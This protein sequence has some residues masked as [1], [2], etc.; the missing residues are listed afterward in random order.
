ML[1]DP[2]AA[3]PV[4]IG[5]RGAKSGIVPY[6]HALDTKGHGPDKTTACKQYCPQAA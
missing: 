6:R 4:T 5:K 2:A 1:Y 3:V